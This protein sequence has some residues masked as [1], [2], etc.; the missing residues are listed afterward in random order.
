MMSLTQTV[1]D[2]VADADEDLLEEEEEVVVVE[3][4]SLFLLKEL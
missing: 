3:D 1:L 4:E 2:L